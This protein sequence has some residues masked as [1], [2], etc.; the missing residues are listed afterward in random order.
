MAATVAVNIEG[1]KRVREQVLDFVSKIDP[2]GERVITTSIGRRDV[3]STKPEWTKQALEAPSANN[4]NV[5]SFATTF[6]LADFTART[7]E[8][9]YT[10]LMDKTVSVDLSH[11]SVNVA[12]VPKGG[13]LVV[14]KELKLNALL[15]DHE[16]A[17]ISAN[18][19]VQPLP[20]SN[21][22]GKLAGMQAFIL[23]NAIAVGSGDFPE[24]E[25][26]PEAYDSLA[27]KCKKKGGSPNKVFC[28]IG[29]KR[30]IA[31][32]VT[33]VNRPV[34]D[35]GKK[36][37]KV[38]NQYETV[39]GMQ[40]IVLSLN[41]TTVLLMIETDRFESGWLREPKWHPYPDGV[42]DYHGGAYKLESTLISLAEESSGK[43]TNLNYAE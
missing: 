23:T 16:A 27:A 19:R 4:T 15:N 28:G 8:Y 37:M 24:R 31:G 18:T 6:A 7:E 9:N 3:E 40:D 20:E 14:Q 43:I 25:L 1:Q 30:A 22:A 26:S 17:I 5:H 13:E 11:E 35:Q 33:Q 21:Q 32:W 29:S 36:L 34:S 39:A 38:V 42:G 10:Q 2:Y 41:L 12:G